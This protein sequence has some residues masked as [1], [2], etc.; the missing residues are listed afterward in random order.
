M[1]AIPLHEPLDPDV[2]PEE[3]TDL[4]KVGSFSMRNGEYEDNDSLMRVLSVPVQDLQVPF[5]QQ[6]F[7]F[8]LLEGYTPGWQPPIVGA[9]QRQGLHS[10]LLWIQQHRQSLANHERPIDAD[11]VCKGGTLSKIMDT[12]HEWD[13]MQRT[14]QPN[15]GWRIGASKFRGTIYLHALMTTERLQHNEE[16]NQNKYMRQTSYGGY[17]F[18]SYISERVQPNEAGEGGHQIVTTAQ[19]ETFKLLYASEVDCLVSRD[20]LPNPDPKDFLEIK[21]R[22][23]AWTPKLEN[24]RLGVMFRLWSQT[25]VR[26]VPAVVVGNREKDFHVRKIEMINTADMPI[27]C[28]EY[29]SSSDS[30]S[31]LRRFLQFVRDTVVVDNPEILYEFSWTPPDEYIRSSEARNVQADRRVLPEWYINFINNDAI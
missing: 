13:F 21:T 17:R 4:R 28:S 30:L 27:L 12:V 29:W 9:E 2:P 19:L 24:E 8:N 25:Y 7:N 16:Q 31:L 5:Q 22:T 3:L 14:G 20:R 18:E 1:P 11:F 23:R 26:G 15:K 10:I 6:R